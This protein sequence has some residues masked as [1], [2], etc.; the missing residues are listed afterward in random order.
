MA[1]KD[2]EDTGNETTVEGMETD[3][4]LSSQDRQTESQADAEMEVDGDGDKSRRPM[5]STFGSRPVPFKLEDDGDDYYIGSV[6][7]NYLRMFRG[8]L[9]RKYPALWRRQT[10]PEERKRLAQMK[11]VDSHSVSSNTILVKAKEVDEIL[12]GYEE[13]YRLV[14][15]DAEI[16]Q[17]PKE[18]KS[19]RASN[20]APQPAT[21]HHL[22]AVPSATPISRARQLMRQPGRHHPFCFDDKPPLMMAKQA[23]QQEILVP[24][25]LDMEIDNVKLR[26]TFTWNKNELLITPEQFAEIL[27]E[28]LDLPM[29]QFIPAIAQS[30]K[31]QVDAFP[32]DN[33]L[34]NQTDQRVVIKLNI[35]VGNISLNDQFEWD[36]AEQQ[37]S[38]EQFAA[39]LCADLGLGGEFETAIA[40]S[41]RAQLTWHQ[42][43]YSDATLPPIDCPFRNHDCD[44]WSP[45]IEVLS[46][47]EME[48]KLRDQ[49]RNTRRMRRLA[50]NQ[51]TSW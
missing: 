41:I 19:R 34:N 44:S 21:S 47:A 26:D 31:Q 40:Y 11:G 29:V 8:Q 48:K 20:W 33:L 12:A 17:T 2:F 28:D 36:M 25:R 9:Y 6:V 3:N 4:D 49:D 13:K 51:G 38:P 30:I 32:T 18:A 5:V 23:A 14:S 35:H 10:T 7:G 50:Y 15:G 22:D 46:D 1:A 37:N 16:S 42:S 39:R 24:I 43:V 27:C 45:S